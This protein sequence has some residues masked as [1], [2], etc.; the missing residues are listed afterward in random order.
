M[1]TP[2]CGTSTDTGVHNKDIDKLKIIKYVRDR[3]KELKGL[4]LTNNDTNKANIMDN[5]FTSIIN[6]YISTIISAEVL[7][8]ILSLTESK[9]TFHVSGLT[10]Q[11]TG[12][13][14]FSNTAVRHEIIV[15]EGKITS[16]PL[17][18]SK[19]LIAIYNAVVPFE[20]VT[21]YLLSANSAIFFSNCN[22]LG[23]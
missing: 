17:G 19:A 15:I 23:P 14:S 3:L 9:H 21:A 16:D 1:A 4:Y 8:V 18:R 6:P 20:Q 2:I 5:L 12:I 22:I 10:S 13:R 11:N 7:S